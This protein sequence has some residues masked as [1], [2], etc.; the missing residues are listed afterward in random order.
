MERA[1]AKGLRVAVGEPIPSV[2]L[3]ATDG[4]LLNLRSF[5]TKQP[6]CFFFFGAP[7][8]TGRE[9]ERGE[10]LASAFARG[11]QRLADAGV[12]LVG[13]TCDS[14]RQQTEYATSRRLPYLI[15]SD[16]RRTAVELLGVPTT[17]RGD[18]F[19]AVRTVIGVDEDGIIRL[20]LTNPDPERVVDEVLAALS[21]EQLPAA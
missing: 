3:R 7:T 6:A 9:A 17:N 11:Y 13:V 4:Y 8:L 12:A 10:A 2:G 20:V 1:T 19:N 5:V 21:G 18:N 16:E 15:F 14:E